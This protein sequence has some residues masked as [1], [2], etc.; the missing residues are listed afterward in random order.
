M[1][2]D[3]TSGSWRNRDAR[4]QPVYP[5]ARALAATIAELAAYPALV[6]PAE[7]DSLEAALAQAQEGRAFLLQGGDC[8]ESFAEFSTAN[9]R[10][11]Y[12]LIA[13][14]AE[15]LAAASGLPIIRLA[16]MA[17]QF[18]KPRSTDPE[19]K[20]SRVLPAYRGDI[21]N[22][23]AFDAAART[24]DPERMFRAYAQSS[25]TLAHLRDLAAADGARIYT[26]HEALLL[27]FE[28]ALVRTDQATGRHYASSA[29]LL[30]IG[31]RTRFP[32]SAHVEFARGLAN[33]LGIKCGPSLDPDTLLTLLDTVNPLRRPGRITLI[34]RM[35]AER[36]ETALPPLLRAVKREGH[37]VLWSCD[38]MHG[39]TIKAASGY[40]TRPLT[41]ILVEVRMFFAVTSAE[42]RAGGGIHIEMTGQDVTECTGGADPVLEQDLADRYHSHCDPRLNARQAIELA[43]LLAET[44]GSSDSAQAA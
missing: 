18:A 32:G 38:P 1:A 30:W 7:A 12:R 36:V 16:R 23:I 5:D 31:D 9:I 40:K 11:S 8:A 33:P 22:G 26:S 28:Q 34:A 20:G 3:W 35:G 21:V 24:P 41:A 13:T 42:G 43:N 29:H 19:T 44:L 6:A 39:N 2:Q 25:A 10:A 15:R 27:P 4:Q 14:I 37:P 17:G